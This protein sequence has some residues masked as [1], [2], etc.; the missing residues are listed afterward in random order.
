MPH[1][2]QQAAEKKAAMS[3][4]SALASEH[5]NDQYAD[6]SGGGGRGGNVK[7]LGLEPAIRWDTDVTGAEPDGPRHRPF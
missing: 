3:V 4:L 7:Q 2:C 1:V 6:S 5:L